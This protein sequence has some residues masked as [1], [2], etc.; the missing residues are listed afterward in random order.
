MAAPYTF[1]QRPASRRRERAEPRPRSPGCCS[2]TPLPLLAFLAAVLLAG[3]ALNGQ[4]QTAPGDIQMPGALPASTALAVPPDPWQ[5]PPRE[6]A[7]A[8]GR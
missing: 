6:T 8:P 7:Q 3:C 4:A 1:G 5:R 2:M